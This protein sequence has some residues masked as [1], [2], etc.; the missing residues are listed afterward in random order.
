MG[1]KKVIDLPGDPEHGGCG[2]E[3]PRRRQ[4]G[5]PDQR[6]IRLPQG[7]TPAPIEVPN[8]PVKTPVEAS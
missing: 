5:F 6:P 3:A 2:S 8:W 4:V 1:D 7:D